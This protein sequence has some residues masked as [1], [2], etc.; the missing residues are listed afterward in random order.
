MTTLFIIFFLTIILYKKLFLIILTF[1]KIYHFFLLSRLS[2]Q[3]IREKN[4]VIIN[5]F[6]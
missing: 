3:K 6:L 1:K 5:F 2:Y 4:E